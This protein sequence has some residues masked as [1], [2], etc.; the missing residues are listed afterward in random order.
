VALLVEG[1]EYITAVVFIAFVK[2]AKSGTRI[3]VTPLR[4]SL[5]LRDSVKDTGGGESN[6]T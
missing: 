5:V 3:D 2:S 6:V 4:G 1:I